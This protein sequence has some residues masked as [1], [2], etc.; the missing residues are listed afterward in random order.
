MLVRTRTVLLACK[1]GHVAF[2]VKPVKK[3]HHL[4]A[5]RVNEWTRSS[6]RCAT[7]SSWSTRRR[8]QGAVRFLSL[9]FAQCMEL[10]AL[11]L[12]VEAEA[13]EIH[14]PC[15]LSCVK[16]STAPE[17]CST[18]AEINEHRSAAQ[19]SASIVVVM[20]SET[21]FAIRLRVLTKLQ[22]FFHLILCVRASVAVMV[23]EE[24]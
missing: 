23:K 2:V 11:S 15:H 5:L 1:Q 21:K 12:R 6:Q 14:G 24:T 7:F 22:S 18:T 20:S 9:C 17:S 16:D 10:M 8:R 4:G 3:V 19:R 13:S